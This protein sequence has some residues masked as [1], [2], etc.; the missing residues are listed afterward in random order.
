MRAAVLYA[1]KDLR[2]ED[3]PSPA[4]G[5]G[6]VLV[7]V[8]LNG[9][10]GTDFSEY[11]HGPLM[12]PLRDRHPVTGHHGPIILGHEF[13]GTVVDAGPAAR[14]WIG[15][16][17]ASGAGV[18]CGRC[19]WCNA[20][21]TNLCD[22]Y[23]TIGLS[24][25]GAL[26]E[27]VAVPQ[28]TLIEIPAACPDEE[29][30]LAQPLAVGLHAIDRAELRGDE[31]VAVLGIGAIGAFI[32][33]GLARHRGPVTAVDVSEERLRV[34][35]ALGATRSCLVSPEAAPDEIRELVGSTPEVV[36]EC[37]GS[38][39]SL[40][41]AAGLVERGG[42]VLLVG[43]QKAPQPLDAAKLV[44]SEVEIRTSVAHVCSRN[45]PDA[46]SLLCAKRI[47]SIIGVHVVPLTTVLSD[48]FAPTA[49]IGASKKF[50][51]D[52]TR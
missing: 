33:T 31:H 10:C 7:K 23:Y 40:G 47:A 43:L 17:V 25:H 13:I 49:R 4:L 15:L 46:L 52:V 6:D 8:A 38:F 12:V 39:G 1:P 18:S 9:L 35:R 16:R 5:N 51:V 3:V 50:V 41:R 11:D 21:R 26:A 45:L 42:R 14:K 32:L 34:A 22:R 24:T 19:R 37:S 30:V 27:Y 29:A 2:I 36:I 44:L 20:G 28:S 48:A